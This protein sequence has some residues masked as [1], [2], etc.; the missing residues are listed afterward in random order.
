M[1]EF[2]VDSNELGEVL[3]EIWPGV[4]WGC[5]FEDFLGRTYGTDGENIVALYL[6]RRGWK[7]TALNRVYIA[8]LRDA[9]ISLYEV[10]E[11]KRG[12]AMVLRNLLADQAPVTVHK[13][14][15]TQTLKSWDRIGAR[16]IR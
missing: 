12:E 15:A 3:G 9:A 1:L 4:L 16:V 13:K 14:S 11:I 5:A 2:D 7:K 8:G 6:K 10:S